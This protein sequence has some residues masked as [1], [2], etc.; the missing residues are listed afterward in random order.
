MF[1]WPRPW[2]PRPKL[3]LFFILG[4]EKLIFKPWRLSCCSG[5][6]RHEVKDPAK[7]SR[8]A[9]IFKT[10][11][12]I[13]KKKERNIYRFFS[14]RAIMQVLVFTRLIK[15]TIQWMK[16][17]PGLILCSGTSPTPL[18]EGVVGDNEGLEVELADAPGDVPE[19]RVFEP[20]PENCQCKKTCFKIS[21]EGKSLLTARMLQT[22]FFLNSHFL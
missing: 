4:W 9:E 6:V 22:V 2:K 10:P 20:R 5:E 12:I 16:K 18:D 14:S 7:L 13:K 1:T 8:Q 11:S 15:V 17:I 3:T 21:I 19:E